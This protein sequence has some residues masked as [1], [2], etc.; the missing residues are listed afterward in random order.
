MSTIILG[1]NHNNTAE[2]YQYLGL[3]PSRLITATEHDYDPG[4]T[5][6]QDIDDLT[7]LE[8]VLSRADQVYWAHPHISEFSDSDSYYDFMDWLKDYNL[9][10]HNLQNLESVVFDPYGWNQKFEPTAN[11]AVFLGCSF[12]AGV[13]LPDPHTHYAHQ[14]AQHF[15]KQLMNL[16]VPGGNNSQIFDRFTQLRCCAGQLVV[17][18][19][20][21]L[22]RINYCDQHKNLS[23]LL[24]STTKMDKD[25][26]RSLL[27]VY[28][29][30]FLFYELLVKIRAMVALAQVQ[31]L[32][33]VFW[34]SDYKNP[35]LYSRLDQTY[36][37]SMKQFVPASWIKNYLVDFA[38]DG[39]HPGV[40][41]NKNI[42]TALIRYI[43]TVYKDQ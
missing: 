29:K 8:T 15:G 36:F 2:Y 28:H 41:S 7:V 20:T 3:S 33:L 21:D 42:A 40:Q 34:L 39:L 37:Y 1:S 19:F 18:Q 14:V 26:H 10:H 23:S 6:V 27:E 38:Q 22:A 13:G 9:R 30:D 11:H 35:T 24:F 32:K 5:S 17:V 25:L 16:S 31:R 43:E 12:T 4:H